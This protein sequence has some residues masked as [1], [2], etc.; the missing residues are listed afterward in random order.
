[1]E[2]QAINWSAEVQRNSDRTDVFVGWVQALHSRSPHENKKSVHGGVSGSDAPVP[3]I[4]YVFGDDGGLWV[5]VVSA[6]LVE[7]DEYAV[8]HAGGGTRLRMFGV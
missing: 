3:G 2:R 4:W 6:E 5:Y 8:F 7:A 1:M